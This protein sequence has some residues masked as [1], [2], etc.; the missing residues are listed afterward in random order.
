MTAT[1]LKTKSTWTEAPF[2][3]KGWTFTYTIRPMNR[4]HHPGKK[5]FVYHSPGG[6]SFSSIKKVHA[7]IDG[8]SV[9]R[10]YQKGKHV[11]WFYYQD[12]KSCFN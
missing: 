2:N 1:K 3:E 12:E 11:R 8:K 7:Y 9:K 6:L 10:T 5:D 4:I